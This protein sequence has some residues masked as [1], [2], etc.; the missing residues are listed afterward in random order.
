MKQLLQNLRTGE[1][2]IA[3]VPCPGIDRG[4]ILIQTRA[5][6]ISAG[7]ERMLMEFGKANIISKARQQPEKVKQVLDKIKTDGLIPTLETVFRKLDEPLTLGYCNSGVVLETGTGVHDILAGDH[8]ISNGPHAEVV[9]VP[10]NLCAKIPDGVTDDQAAFSVLASI[11]LQSLRLAAPTLGEKFMVFGMGLIGLL[12][13]Q[14]LK[15]SG[16]E[17]LGIDYNSE[18]LKLAEIFGAKTIDLS[19][20]ADPIISA[21]V[22]TRDIGVDAAII[23]ASAKNDDIIH[24]AAESCR[25]RGRIVLVGVVGLNLRRS[26]FYE[27]ELTFQVSCSYGPGRYDEKYEQKGHD[28]PPGYVRW[29]EGRNF[30]AVLGAMASGNLNVEPLITHRYKLN[31]ALAAYD[32]IQNDSSALGIVL[33]YNEHINRNSS[34]VITQRTSKPLSNVTVGI[35]GAGNFTVGTILPCLKN[36]D[37]RLKY[38]AG[39]TRPA[40][41][42]HAAKKFN[43]ENAVTDYRRILDDKEVNTI[44]IATKHHTHACMAIEGLEAGKHVFVEKP[45]AITEQQLSDITE[46][47]KKHPDKFLMVGFNRRFSPHTIRIKELLSKRCGPLCMN[48]TVNAGEIPTDH[49]TQDLELGGGRIIGEG[50]HFIDLLSYITSSPVHA[51]SAMMVG[52]GP[53]IQEDKM[54]IV[55]NFM[56]GSIG[57]INYFA[58][59]SKSYPKETLEIFNDGRVLKMENFR[60]TEGYRFAGFRKFKTMR[61]NKGHKN[62]IAAFIELIRTGGEPLIP[63]EQLAHVTHCSFVVMESARK[64]QTKII[65]QREKTEKTEWLLSSLSHNSSQQYATCKADR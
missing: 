63:F 44:F 60:V 40:N 30:E 11:A 14:L 38:I 26:D 65:G 39:K 7:T 43:I 24:Q 59:G 45:L 21:K 62:E 31:N 42:R 19:K 28:Y 34:V 35:I 12:T 23:T 53:V 13:V 22:W 4:Q 51:V 46:T 61:Q 52:N 3:E 58:N 17:V 18:R 20:G 36:T 56:D 25:K 54:S 64:K 41:I 37:A 49:W 55:L 9:C 5:S 57:T 8:V 16:C 50:C 27:K 10:R 32:K 6:L 33:K 2:E 29:T 48:M 1:I 15:A 47:V